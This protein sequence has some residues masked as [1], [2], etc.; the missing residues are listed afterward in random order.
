LISR[1]FGFP[2]RKYS[3]VRGFKWGGISERDGALE[4]CLGAPVDC[5]RG[6]ADV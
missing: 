3:Q 2:R 6:D 1:A 5:R 4:G